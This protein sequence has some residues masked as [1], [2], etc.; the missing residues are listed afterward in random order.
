M[1]DKLPTPFEIDT[2]YHYK[3][4][5]APDNDIPRSAISS[6]GSWFIAQGYDSLYYFLDRLFTWDSKDSEWR[7]WET[8]EGKWTK[9]FSKAYYESTG[10]KK[11]STEV[12]AKAGELIRSS[13]VATD[14]YFAFSKFV[15]WQV[16]AFQDSRGRDAQTSPFRRLAMSHTFK[17]VDKDCDDHHLARNQAQKDKNKQ[18]A[19]LRKEIAKQ[20][21]LGNYDRVAELCA[22]L[23]YLL[24]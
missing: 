12:L 13:I 14:M 20:R 8:A 9:R 18:A 21:E 22:E 15:D 4:G 7:K 19:E 23:N 10:G 5:D 11:I 16:N 24:A 2:L 17:D 1:K 3:P 6:V